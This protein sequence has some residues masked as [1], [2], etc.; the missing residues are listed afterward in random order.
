[1]A[2]GDLLRREASAERAALGGGERER[3]SV[4]AGQACRAKKGEDFAL[5]KPACERRPGAPSTS[6]SAFAVSALPPPPSSTRLR[7]P[8]EW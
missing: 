2:L 1:V 8:N 7:C 4:A 3:P 5:L 6:F